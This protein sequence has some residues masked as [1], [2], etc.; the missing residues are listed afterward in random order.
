M[1]HA[2]CHALFSYLLPVNNMSSIAALTSVFKSFVIA[3]SLFLCPHMVILTFAENAHATDVCRFNINFS[4]E[5]FSFSP[6]TKNTLHTSNLSQTVSCEGAS[7]LR[8]L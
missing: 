2:F 8:I 5:L 3:S 4:A 6:R 1:A 7:A